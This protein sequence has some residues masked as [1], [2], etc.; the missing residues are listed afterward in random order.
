M[1]F[2]FSL[3]SDDIDDHQLV[4]AADEADL[5]FLDLDQSAV[6][7]FIEGHKNAATKRKTE[8]HIRL[9][10]MFLRRRGEERLPE[11]IPPETLNNLLAVFFMSVRK[12]NRE[13]YQPSTLRDMQSSFERYLREKGYK[14]SII[15]DRDFEKS[16]RTLI[17][18]QKELKKA[19]KGNKPQAAQALTDE[20]RN[21]LYIKRQL[22]K[23]G[24][25]AIINTMWLN[26]TIHFG[27][28][29]VD[30]HRKLM[31]GDIKLETDNE[32]GFFLEFNERDTKT[33]TGTDAIQL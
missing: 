13:E 11:A 18:K 22:G 19:G 29:G 16:R 20:E 32:G 28:R 15:S 23:H 5:R 27:L 31:W 7:D 30:E 21:T 6:N 10:E 26:N 25:Q 8:G 17:A 3:Q 9:L 12:V 14:H 4:E 24:P 1:F 2:T 33:R